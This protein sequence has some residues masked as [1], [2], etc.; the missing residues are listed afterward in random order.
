MSRAADETRT[1]DERVNEIIAEYLQ[2]ADAGRAPD[3]AELLARHA[4]IA[5]ELR[6]FF[7]DH[8]RAGRLAAPP[9]LAAHEPPTAPSLGRVRYFGD[10]ELLAEVA[11]GAMGVVYKARQMSLNRV[12]ALKMILSG[13]LA[14]PADVQ[15]FRTEAENAA[16]LDHPNIVP[17]YEV[18]EH[19]GQHYFSMKLIEGGSLSQHAPRL[20]QDRRA[21]VR[22]LADVAR[23]V[24]HAHRHGILHRDLKPGN[25]LVDAEGRPHVTDFGLARRLHAEASLSPA[26]AVLGTPSYMPPEQAAPGQGRLTTAAD[27]YA[28]GAIFYELLTGRPPFRADTPLDVLLQVLQKEPEPPRAVDPHIDSDLETICLKCLQKDPRRR[29]GSAEALADDLERWLR[30]EPILARPSGAGERALKWVRRR[31]AAAALVG[32]SGLALLSVGVLVAVLWSDAE[33]RALQEQQQ[34]LQLQEQAEKERDLNHQLQQQR[35]LARDEARNASRNLYAARVNLMQP[36]WDAGFVERVRELL[37]A[38]LADDQKEWRGFEWY[39]YWALAHQERF[40]LRGHDNDSMLLGSMG[41]T[42]TADSGKTVAFGAGD[43]VAFATADGAVQLADLA[44]GKERF[45]LRGHGGP[46]NAVAFSADGKLLA[47]ASADRTAKLWDTATG[48]LRTTLSGHLDGFEAVAFSPD[49]TMVATGSADKSIKL[50]DAATGKERATLKG[51]TAA[52]FTV[53]FAPD[54]KTLVTKCRRLVVKLWDVPGAT[55]KATLAGYRGIVCQ[56]AFSPDGRTLATGTT[57]INIPL[58]GSS[59]VW[60]DAVS[61]TT[62]LFPNMDSEVVLWDTATGKEKAR[63]PRAAGKVTC[64]AFSPDGKAL[65]AGNA[66]AI[67]I[68]LSF[69]ELGKG[70]PFVPFD[71]PGRLTLW[72]TT[73][74]KERVSR[75]YQGG[76][77]STTFSADGRQLAVGAGP[78]GEVELMESGTGKL[79]LACRGHTNAVIAAAFSGDGK[80]LF[81]AGKDG[82]IKG[83]D[84]AASGQPLS[85]PAIGV[86]VAYS[87]RGDLYLSRG[88]R[89]DEATRTWQKLGLGGGGPIAVSPDGKTLATTTSTL[90]PPAQAV[91]LWD[92]ATMKQQRILKAGLGVTPAT[93]AFSPDSK[94]LTTG[95]QSVK[96]WDVATGRQ[97]VNLPGPALCVAFSPDGTALA[98]AGEDNAVRLWDAGAWQRVNPEKPPGPVILKGHAQLALAVAFSPDGKTLASGGGWSVA[99]AARPG[100][101]ILWDLEARTPRAHLKGH[102]GG[103]NAVAFSHDGKTLATGGDDRTVRLWRADTGQPLATLTGHTIAV[104]A[105]V[106]RPDDR[107]LAAVGQDFSLRLWSAATDE[108]VAAR[109]E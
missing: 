6:S 10:Y 87:P 64:V 63:L 108:E 62:L 103:V 11:R 36:A 106:F 71:A 13:Q 67:T 56:E 99:V 23:A 102:L 21:V 39:H 84:A 72:D 34:K 31:P 94:V 30:G 75:E 48:E 89:W 66:G 76:V 93:L 24:Q 91:A 55:E 74:L 85:I 97:L 105:V 29:Y 86:G 41:R 92:V 12:V 8:D 107:V 98:T 9:T 22:L 81:T 32:V 7:A 37:R 4:D 70:Q 101:V 109:G 68:P 83:W 61:A 69:S 14:A 58:L 18:G 51:H 28:L 40:T 45:V 42:V 16:S 53:R 78:L 1:R 49:A 57:T 95:G 88:S 104:T 96:L 38:Q 20:R 17:I 100:E 33:A 27:V 25:I 73:T 79:L 43:L 59:S 35:D 3:R 46:V 77:W 19:E 52:L 50:W 26:G 5:D 2:A 15:R 60:H 82:T 44:L 54:G 47:T 90:F 80:N 65:T